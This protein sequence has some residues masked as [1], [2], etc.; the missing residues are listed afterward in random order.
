MDTILKAIV[1]MALLAIAAAAIWFAISWRQHNPPCPSTAEVLAAYST[2]R[3]GGGSSKWQDIP[4]N[5]LNFPP[6]PSQ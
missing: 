6:G 2:A 5:C 1:G 4:I 3:A